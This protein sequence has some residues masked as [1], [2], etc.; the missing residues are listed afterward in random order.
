MENELKEW[1]LAVISE[2]MEH[3]DPYWFYENVLEERLDEILNA[4]TEKEADNIFDG[5]YLDI[6][7]IGILSPRTEADAG[8]NECHK[9]VLKTINKYKQGKGL[10]QI[11]TP[12]HPCPECGE[13]MVKPK[14]KVMTD[15]SI[16]SVFYRTGGLWD[17]LNCGKTK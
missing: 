16:S 13:E 12:K 6:A 15:G 7:S 4:N 5:I 2:M 9:R 11:K 1:L 10:F 14:S 17:C 3:A 8:W